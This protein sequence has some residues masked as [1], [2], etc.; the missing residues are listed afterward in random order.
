MSLSWDAVAFAGGIKEYE[1]FRD[2]VSVGTRVGTSFNE[3]GLKPETTYKY[4]VRAISMAGNPSELS[5]ELSVTTEPTPV[6]DP[7]SISVSPSSK[8]LNVGETRQI[9]A[10]VSPSGADQGVT[11]TSSNTSI[12]TVTSSGKVTAVAAGS[13]TITVK[14][15]V[16]T[17]VKNTVSITVVDPA[18]S[19]GE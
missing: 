18:P 17:T 16:K 7:E 6:P 9:T 14:S 13:A 1:I 10:T 15:K 19:G 3:S 2:G 12:A 5:D 11:Y 4:Q 8:T